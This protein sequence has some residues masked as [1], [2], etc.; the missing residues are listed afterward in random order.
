MRSFLRFV[1]VLLFLGVVLPLSAQNK[2][3]QFRPAVI[4]A[5]KDSLINRIDSND[6]LK[7]GQKDGAVMFCALVAPNG[8]A[9][10]A[11]TYRAMP[12]T[13]PLAQE[14]ERRFL[15]LKFTPPIYQYQPVSVLL[16]GTAIFSAAGTPHIQIFLN[17][18]PD[19]IKAL[20]DFVAPQ[21]VIG[22]DSKFHGLTLPEGGTPVPMKAVV[23]T[24]LKVDRN[25]ELK[26]LQVLNEEPPLLGFGAAIVADFQ[27]AKFIPAF[28]Y[29]DPDDCDIP[30]PI[31]FPP[32]E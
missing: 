8:D 19:E 16:F 22:G 17:Q 13:E 18:D 26:D 3:P 29:G 10:N 24:R 25:G 28:R 32:T 21:P 1:G 5:G 11:W 2:R 4:G 12:G 30:Q 15:N 27:G 31:C 9:T 6:L 23:D 20:H 14:L 7:K